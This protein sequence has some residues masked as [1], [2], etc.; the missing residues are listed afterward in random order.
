MLTWTLIFLVVA[1]VAGVL[2]FGGI[3]STAAGFARVLFFV[4]LVLF[5]VSLI[6]GQR[7]F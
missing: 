1:I 5:A 3:A 4:F 6:T 7:S 2:G